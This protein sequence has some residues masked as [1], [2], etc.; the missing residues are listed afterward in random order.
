MTEGI[1]G[2]VEPGSL[3]GRIYTDPDIF[4]REMEKIFHTSWVYVG[5]VSEIPERG[6][7][8]TSYIGL[9]PVIVTHAEDDSIKVML[10][11]CRHRAASVCLNSTGNAQFFRCQYHGWTY[12]NT[13]ELV[14]VT[15]PRGYQGTLDFPSHSLFIV[16][17]VDT[18]NGFIF[19]RIAAEGETL[20]EHL[21]LAAGFI[22][23]FTAMS[24]AN[25]I[26]AKSGVH[27][28]QFKAN[29]KLQLENSVDGYHPAV[30]HRSWF[31]VTGARA[32]IEN[33]GL[34]TSERTTPT[35]TRDLGNGHSVLDKGDK[36]LDDLADQYYN[37]ASMVKGGPALL[38]RLHAELGKD[39][40]RD[41][42]NSVG[43]SPFNIAIFPNLVLVRSHIRVIQP[44]AVD[45][46]EVLLYPITLD[47][48]DDEVNA[49]RLR[50]HEMFFGP[51][52]MGQPDDVE[53][54]AR[55]QVG[56][57]AKTGGR[58]NISRGMTRDESVDGQIIGSGFDETPFRGQYRRWLELMN[59][60]ASPSGLKIWA[61][62]EQSDEETRG[63]A[64]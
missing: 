39:A 35:I 59:R 57:Q 2:L 1:D 17:N 13:G 4:D 42:I 19:A 15:H 6:D 9:E 56:L 64:Q 25:K 11:R 60:P 40:T 53:M 41:F 16:A 43:G 10:N 61:D 21:G 26:H 63:N 28:T 58:L 27:R 12:R 33:R 30:T 8:R 7:Y 34:Y 18:Y 14:G 22:D 38:E 55:V 23:R 20:L 3:D 5:H 37:Q 47:G 62:H 50:M 54:F 46:T 48:V 36:K 52:G 31:D 29:W 24:P 44:H 49:V 32:G 51:S 45:Q